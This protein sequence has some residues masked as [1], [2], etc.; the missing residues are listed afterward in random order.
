[1]VPQRCPHPNPPNQVCQLTH[2]IKDF[3]DVMKDLILRRGD[4]PDYSS[5]PN[6]IMSS[7][8]GKREEPEK[9]MYQWKQRLG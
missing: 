6:V 1:M 7:Y 5:G 3:V 4:Y 9:E 8:T 2:G